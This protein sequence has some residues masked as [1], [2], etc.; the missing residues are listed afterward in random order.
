ML[1]LCLVFWKSE[2]HMLI[3]VMLIKEKNV[4]F[5][6]SCKNLGRPLKPFWRKVLKRTG[7]AK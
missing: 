2:L 3:N 6:L 5:L 7:R 4:F 1:R